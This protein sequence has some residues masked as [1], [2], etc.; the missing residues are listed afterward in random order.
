MNK[1][2]MAAYLANLQ[3]IMTFHDGSGTTKNAFIVGEYIRVH[4]DLVKQLEKD[5]E[6]GSK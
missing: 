1:S 4:S 3:S 5:N 6:A 2:E